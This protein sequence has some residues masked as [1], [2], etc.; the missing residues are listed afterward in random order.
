M[1]RAA[2]KWRGSEVGSLA[3]CATYVV[4]QATVPSTRF[5]G[6]KMPRM[7]LVFC[8]SEVMDSFGKGEEWLKVSVE[9]DDVMRAWEKSTEDEDFSRS[10]TLWFGLMGLI[11]TTSE[12]GLEDGVFVLVGSLAQKHSYI[13]TFL[14]DWLVNAAQRS[15]T[16]IKSEGSHSTKH[17]SVLRE[18]F[19]RMP[20]SG[21]LK[22]ANP[23]ILLQW[24]LLYCKSSDGQMNQGVVGSL[25]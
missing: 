18:I 7:D 25:M 12:T 4:N 8:R 21:T 16:S 1:D 22:V 3:A 10:A 20:P 11:G 13:N 15:Q 17:V 14:P 24:S 2:R 23:P 5:L 19:A 9:S 6:T